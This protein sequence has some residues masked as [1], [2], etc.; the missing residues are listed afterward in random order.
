MK[1]LN[2][3]LKHQENELK[4]TREKFALYR[5]EMNDTEVRLESLTLDLEMAEEKVSF[6]SIAVRC[7]SITFVFFCSARNRYRR[8]YNIKRKT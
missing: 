2:D 6:P 4:E 5:D 7:D 3:K 8:K 1:E